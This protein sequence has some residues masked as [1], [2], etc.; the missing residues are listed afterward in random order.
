MPTHLPPGQQITRLLPKAFPQQFASRPSLNEPPK[1]LTRGRCLCYALL[2]AA[3][4]LLI[5]TIPWISA[6]IVHDW[7]VRHYALQEQ[8]P[9]APADLD[10][11]S[12]PADLETPR[13]APVPPKE[14]AP[15][16]V[17]P[18]QLPA[19]AAPR[20]E[21]ELPQP[22]VVQLPPAPKE[23]SQHPLPPLKR[24]DPFSAEDLQKQLQ[25]VPE[26]SVDGVPA[27]TV[28]LRDL[29]VAYRKRG[30]IFP[31]PAV[32]L[33]SRP[34]WQGLS[35]HQ[36]LDAELKKE[37]AT[38][39]D[40]LSP[41][42]HGLLPEK[43]AKIDM[44][45]ESLLRNSND[46]KWLNADAVPCLVQ[47]LQVEDVPVRL[48]L[49]EALGK[50]VDRQATRALAKRAMTDLDAS[51]REAAA[52]QL[53][54]RQ[55]EDYRALLIGGLRYPW[56]PVALHAAE[57]LA[58]VKDTDAVPELTKLLDQPDTT[59]PFIVK[60]NGKEVFVTRE[61]VRI[62]HLAGCL[63]CHAP[64]FSENDLV[65]GQVPLVGKPLPVTWPVRRWGYGG[66][67]G[68]FGAAKDDDPNA[69][70]V[71]ASATFLRQ[72]FSVKQPVRAH[73]Y[74]PEMQRY[75]YLVRT[76]PATAAELQL[77]TQKNPAAAPTT[78]RQAIQFALRELTGKDQ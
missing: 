3:A 37:A 46:N 20:T 34:D 56:A 50:I 11:L 40:N 28:R 14:T 51:V 54:K 30:E 27:T 61:V 1:S 25:H 23:P 72:D 63:L 42:L 13:A 19:A 9:P 29:A 41:D 16:A 67:F 5:V 10:K 62:N 57:T 60:Q 75:D 24:I 74:W 71:R 26:V 68:G 15:D 36:G 47:M 69:I 70:F 33:A 59:L 73:G 52:Q 44:F 39:L 22:P 58:Y 21:E 49:V 35:F 53:L 17:A 2:T 43:T 7:L 76:R 6:C 4:A 66:G 64:S 32:L 31:G 8:T 65:R 45:R 78:S 18:V 12:D 38:T 77:L 48:V 55:P